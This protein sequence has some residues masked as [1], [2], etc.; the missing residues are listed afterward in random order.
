MF[1]KV[2]G[3]MPGGGSVTQ[4]EY[5]GDVFALL[6]QGEV[7]LKK[8]ME[9]YPNDNTQDE[10]QS[11]LYTKTRI[12][13][14]E[15]MMEKLKRRGLETDCRT[16]LANTHDAIGIRVICSFVE[17]VY[18]SKDGCKKERILKSWKKKIISLIRRQMVTGVFI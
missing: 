13:T 18:R 7:Y 10:L 15:S 12:K 16:A 11:I 5:Y 4:E 14:P 6:K 17:E 1:E 8:V 3:T 9:M 2:V